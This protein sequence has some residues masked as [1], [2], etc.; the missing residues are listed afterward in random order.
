LETQIWVIYVYLATGL[1]ERVQDVK[2]KKRIMIIE[3]SSTL[4][5]Q[6]HEIEKPAKEPSV[7]QEKTWAS[8]AGSRVTCSIKTC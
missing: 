4:T 7:G 8:D 3:L 6:N 1:G 5:F 2:G